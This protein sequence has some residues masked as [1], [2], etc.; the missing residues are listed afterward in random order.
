MKTFRWLCIA[1]LA[2]VYSAVAWVAFHPRVSRAYEDYYIRRSTALSPTQ[3]SALRPIER[4]RTYA[5]G[6]A[7]VGY[8]A[9]P[10]ASLSPWRTRA[11]RSQL[12]FVLPAGEAPPSFLVVGFTS[13]APEHVRWQLNGGQPHEARIGTDHALRIALD[14]QDL[15]PG[16]NVVEFSV[17]DGHGS[18]QLGRALGTSAESF[19]FD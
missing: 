15:R 12:V 7:V 19:R 8:A 1:A 4:G 17:D 10:G 2:V 6:D 11:P 18:Y 9:W 16:E 13:S 3:R 5:P 14:A